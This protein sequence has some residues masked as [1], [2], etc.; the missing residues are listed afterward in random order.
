MEKLLG[1]S[2]LTLVL[3]LGVVGAELI[4]TTF[5]SIGYFFFVVEGSAYILF[6]AHF[7]PTCNPDASAT[8][9]LSVSCLF[10][11]SNQRFCTCET[12]ILGQ[13]SGGIGGDRVV[14]RKMPVFFTPNPMIYNC[15][16][17]LGEG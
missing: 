17:H 2:V 1:S 9:R 16:L 14:K 12:P 4:S 6:A 15:L 11:T 5:L 10:L 7:H 8:P 13:G 3:F